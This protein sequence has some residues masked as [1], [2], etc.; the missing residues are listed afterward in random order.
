MRQL[1]RM[2]GRIFSQR[3]DR[4]KPLWEFWV[5]EGLEN[6]RF[7]IVSKI[8]HCMVDG[9]SGAELIS[10]LLTTEPHEKPE[11]QRI[12]EP[13]PRPTAFELGAAEVARYTR[14]PL[15]A[16][17][18][19]LRLAR[20]EE[21]SRE[22]AAERLRGLGRMLSGM[23]GGATAVPFNQPVGPHRR[24]DWMPMS[25]AQIKDIRSAV[26]GT[27]NDV[28][29]ATAA[30]A[31][32]RFLSRERGVELR[33]IHFRVMAPVNMRRPDEDKSPG[34]RV[35]MW[36]IDLPIDEPDP[37]GRL[38]L[39]REQTEELKSSKTAL[40][41][42][43]ISEATEWMGSGVL[44]LGVRLA[45]QGTPINSVITNIPGPRVPQYLLD[46]RMLEIHPHVPLMGNVGVGIAL[47]SYEG[48]LSWG[49]S[50]DWDLLPDLH[51]LVN[52]TQRSFEELMEAARAAKSE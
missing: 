36:T 15:D 40:G 24:I 46:S 37:L 39:V 44:S 51:D 1:K 14:A 6:D 30:G 13:R 18:A 49:F 2:V 43:L 5:I 23:S 31:F 33:D 3:L 8:H 34:N 4:E 21:G 50:A 38:V 17:A 16:A 32:G 42:E 22:H 26:G 10:A 29:L 7:A 12:W 20:N 25:I 48:V 9:V 35:A 52:A 45:M 47:F 11:P 27:L 41:A 28:V 19:M